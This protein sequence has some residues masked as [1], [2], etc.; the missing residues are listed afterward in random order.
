MHY[1]KK[2][3]KTLNL[4]NCGYIVSLASAQA[5]E[6]QSPVAITRTRVGDGEKDAD[7]D[8]RTDPDDA[9]LF[10][11][12]GSTGAGDAHSALEETHKQRGWATHFSPSAAS[13]TPRVYS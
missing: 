1:E 7:E 9:A 11:E 4:S 2:Y 3:L 6:C 8:D 12:W 13:T 10:K 5:T